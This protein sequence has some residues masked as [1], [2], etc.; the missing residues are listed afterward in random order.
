MAT[1]NTTL[2]QREIS[3]SREHIS[4]LLKVI[5][6]TYADYK[7]FQ[8][9]ADSE[10]N[11]KL[12]R[13]DRNAANALFNKFN[14]QRTELVTRLSE[15]ALEITK[16]AEKLEKFF[17]PFLPNFKTQQEMVTEKQK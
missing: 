17:S 14:E 4:A 8:T 12:A 7:A 16:D 11:E 5:P 2:G 10:K 13:A 9:R 6:E 1:Q 3:K 15:V